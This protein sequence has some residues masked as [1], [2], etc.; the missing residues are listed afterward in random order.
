VA[1][2]LSLRHMGATSPTTTA[3]KTRSLKLPTV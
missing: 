3:T 2:F 1:P